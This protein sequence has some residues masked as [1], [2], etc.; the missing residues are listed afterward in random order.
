MK[1]LPLEL[2]YLIC[3]DLDISDLCNLICSNS[4]FITATYETFIKRKHIFNSKKKKK[5]IDITSILSILNPGGASGDLLMT[6]SSVIGSSVNNSSGW[7]NSKSFSGVIHSYIFGYYHP[8]M[9]V[10]I[11]KLRLHIDDFSLFDLYN[12]NQILNFYK[13][14]LYDLDKIVESLDKKTNKK[15]YIKKVLPKEFLYDIWFKSITL[16]DTLEIT[17]NDQFKKILGY[18]TL[19]MMDNFRDALVINNKFLVLCFKKKLDKV[20]FYLI[21]NERF[22]KLSLNCDLK[23]VILKLACEFGYM[24][25]VLHPQ[26]K[27][28][29]DYRMMY[30][31]IIHS[32][33]EF[34]DL[35]WKYRHL[36]INFNKNIQHI[37]NEITSKNATQLDFFEWCKTHP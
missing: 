5:P 25:I 31:S 23:I 7:K 26:L 9:N 22:F 21:D 32:P 24:E 17:K 35:L 37:S 10:F 19:E 30:F 13:S 2:W 4:F 18:I 36:I 6:I 11:D 27:N 34:L 8:K 29:F 12:K 1:H 28:L 3:K 33:R 16:D 20:L 14:D 15:T